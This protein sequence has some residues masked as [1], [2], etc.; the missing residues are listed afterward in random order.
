[1]GQVEIPG[2]CGEIIIMKQILYNLAGAG[3]VKSKQLLAASLTEVYL[4]LFYR[5]GGVKN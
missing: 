3:D 4:C 2:G 5:E 1:M